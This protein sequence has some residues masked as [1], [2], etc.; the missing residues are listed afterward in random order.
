MFPIVG[1]VTGVVVNAW[2]VYWRPQITERD[3]QRE[4]EREDKRADGT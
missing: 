1:W 4:I 3:T 2:D